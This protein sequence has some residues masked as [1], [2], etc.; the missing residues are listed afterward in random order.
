M[1]GNKKGIL[2]TMDALLAALIIVSSITFISNNYIL[3]EKSHDMSFISYDLVKSFSNIKTG[4]LNNP[5]LQSLIAS[6]K[7]NNTNNSILETIGE[8][9]VLNQT[10]IAQNL[11]KNISA[12]MI[13]SRFGFAINVNGENVYSNNK[14]ILKSLVTAKRLISGIEK[15]KPI[16]GSASKAYL[17]GIDKKIESTYIFYGGFIGQGNI[18]KFTNEIPNDANITNIYLELETG[19]II[20]DQFNIYINK[21][22]CNGDFNRTSNV[23]EANFFDIT[24]CNTSIVPG[25]INNISI[26]FI[27]NSNLDIAYISGGFFRFDYYTKRLNKPEIPGYKKYNFPSIDGIINIYSSM[28][29]PGNITNMNLCLKYLVNHTNSTNSTFYL[30]IGNDTIITDD[31]STTIQNIC[32]PNNLLNQSVN[33]SFLS[34]KNI[35]IR[36]GAENVS[37]FTQYVGNADAVL[38][39]DVSGS[40]AWRMSDSS[41]GI[42]RDCDDPNLGNSDTRRI[43][44][45]ECLDKNFTSD[46]LNISGNLVGLVSYEQNTQETESLTNNV[47]FLTNEINQYSSE[48]G[49]GTCICCGINSA[50]DLLIADFGPSTL[51]SSGSQWLYNNFSLKGDPSNDTQNNTWSSLIYLNESS[52][53]SG[54]AILGATNG[55]LYSPVVIT[56]MG[57]SFNEQIMGVSE[58]YADLWENSGDVVGPPNDFTS[59]VLNQTA[60]TFGIGLGD[61]GWDTSD[62]V[63]DYSDPMLDYGFDNNVRLRIRSGDTN[64]N[65]VSGAFGIEINITD[66]MINLIN[67]SSGDAMLSFDWWWDDKASGS[68]RFTSSNEVWVKAFWE[69]P[70]S[71]VH[72]LGGDYDNGHTP[73]DAY[74][75]IYASEDP[76]GDDNGNYQIS[77]KNW[78]EGSGQYFLALGGKLE[79]DESDEEGIWRFDNIQLY[80]SGNPNSSSSDR[81]Y[82][83]LWEYSGDNPG[84]P[85]DFSSGNLNSTANTY[86]ISG[87]DD[88]WDYDSPEDGSGPFGY[89]DDIDYN[90]ISSGM[91]EFDNNDGGSGNVCSSRD[92]SGAYGIEINIT[93]ELYDIIQNNG[94]AWVSFWYQWDD[95]SG[96]YFE[97]ADQVWVKARFTNISGSPSTYLGSDLDSSNTG[98]DSDFEVYTTDNP[99]TDFSGTFSQDISDLISEPGNYYLEIGGKILTSSSAE[100]GTWRFDDIS[101]LV[102]NITDYYYL[103]KNFTISDISQVQKGIMN[104]MSDDMVSIYLNG[105]EVYSDSQSNTAEYWNN[106]GVKIEGGNFR[107]GNNV[108]AVKLQNFLQASKFDLELIGLNSSRSKAIISMTDGDANQQCAEQGTGSSSQDAI[109]AACD[110]K[111]NYGISVYAVGIGDDPDIDTL[112]GIAQCGGG[113][114][115]K[116]DNVSALSEFYKDVAA[117]I[118]DVARVEQKIVITGNPTLSKLFGTESFIE[119]NYTDTSPGLGVGK[120]S[121]DLE[122][123]LS[124]NCSFYFNISPKI[125]VI[126]AKVSGYSSS[127][128]FD[129]LFVNNITVHNL[130]SFNSDYSFLGDPFSLSFDPSLLN[131]GSFDNITIRTGIFSSNSTGCSDN[132]TFFYKG[133]LDATVSYSE[134][135]ET[136]EGCNWTV[137]YDD[138]FN[139]TFMVPPSYSGSNNC[140]YTNETLVYNQNDTYDDAMYR[141]LSQLDFDSDGRIFVNLKKNG[142]IIDAIS[143]HKV[144]YPWGPAIA[145]VRVWQ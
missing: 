44:V 73:S 1:F 24:S 32:F 51:I 114:Y 87:N 110:A 111:E 88:G 120:I 45:A 64:S 142:L 3:D 117:E 9:Y 62:G 14:T 7:I 40:M 66:Q 129:F 85:N 48:T 136:A 144:P 11:T 22:Q 89:D 84:A 21:I 132:S 127:K 61:D 98:G 107:A 18:T 35:P 138:G 145:E 38:I 104:I 133:L 95:R 130:S 69:S 67:S 71:G 96:N 139:G 17:Q 13:P 37:F 135:L 34:G 74:F 77:V 26:S 33:Y 97:T 41:S 82:V 141:L 99:N 8:L 106:K 49:G 19:D 112:S 76:D 25:G 137:Q 90:L 29:V 43:S 15:F 108:L 94:Q 16:K 58:I 125:K 31:N 10:I 80:I 113:L 75:E 134:V 126:E 70:T 101:L 93:D 23:M 121:L 102:S 128:W 57:S 55:Y 124:G 131:P 115:T 6:G 54:T 116:S 86:G 143:V 53:N 20:G 56:E 72:Y 42:N 47:T 122:Q 4:E 100:Y 92:C 30:K 109:Q 36:M 78:I 81:S 5:Y 63:F 2:F 60:N 27:P 59:K 103:R 12:Q 140:V 118:M 68:N 65:D 91:I 52:W 79:R 39:T 50:R 28:Y 119:F 83:D 105:N 46:M 123:P